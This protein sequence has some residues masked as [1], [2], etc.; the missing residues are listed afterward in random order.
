MQAFREP[1][2][3]LLSLG[4]CFAL[5]GTS[6][7]GPPG[8][9]TF[10]GGDYNG[11]GKGDLA[12]QG[13]LGSGS[14]GTVRVDYLDGK[15][16]LGVPQFLADGGGAWEVIAGTCVD[17][18]NDGNDDIM[19]QGR[20][21]TPAFGAVRIHR[22]QGQGVAP[23]LSWL[24]NGGG[25]WTLFGA[26]DFDGNGTDDP[27]FVGENGTSAQG[28]VKVEL[29]LGMAPKLFIQTAG[30]DYV[31]VGTGDANGD[32]MADMMFLGTGAAAGFYRYTAIDG[33]NPGNPVIKHG[34]YS[35]AG[36]AWTFVGFG[37]TDG[38]GDDEIGYQGSGGAA[39]SARIQN[40]DPTN[41]AVI[42]GTSFFGSGAF[43]L[44]GLAD[45]DNDGD[46][47]AVY[48]GAASNRVDILQNNA[49]TGT[50]GFPTNSDGNYSLSQLSDLDGT[51]MAD[52]VSVGSGPVLGL[53]NLQIMNAQNV[54]DTGTRPNA[55][56]TLELK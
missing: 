34:F 40:I 23:Q 8:G 12:Y 16:L 9:G 30:G 6:A 55:G 28:L 2:S 36:G 44:F 21:G 3:L 52:L 54:A 5:A 1:F 20:F 15:T 31:L 17:V 35:N 18:D 48:S 53:V 37:D 24:S 56:G 32:G 43:N 4:I 39:G 22:M 42:L 14:Q 29:N 51:T 26:D 7:A 41:V 45:M 13:M 46:A 27:V 25:I 19:Y 10:V 49:G 38:D 50:Q 47:D 11:D 33:T